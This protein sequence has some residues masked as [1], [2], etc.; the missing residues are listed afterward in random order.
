MQTMPDPASANIR[1]FLDCCHMH[2]RMPDFV[3]DVW[4]D[5]IKYPR[6]DLF[7][8]LNHN[9]KD[10]N[11]DDQSHNWIGKRVTKPNAEHSEKHCKTCPPVNSSMLAIGNQSRAANPAP[12]A[13]TKNRYP[14][15]T[16]K[17]NNRSD[18]DRPKMRNILRM[19]KAID[20]LVTG[21]NRAEKNDEYNGRAREIL[22]STIAEGKSLVGSLTCKKKGN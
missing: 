6:K 5:A 9:S 14:F 22:D 1:Y 4:L 11:C 17:T 18:R 7:A 13:N 3:N 16:E 12:D 20:A 8:T 2:C 15:I 19:K 21:D 10:R